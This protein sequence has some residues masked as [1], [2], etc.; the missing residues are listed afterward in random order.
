M[1][2]SNA[3][4]LWFLGESQLRAYYGTPEGLFVA[5][6][7][8]RSGSF[9]EGARVLGASV[10]G[11]LD[12]PVWVAPKEDVIFYSSPGPGVPFDLKRPLRKLWMIRY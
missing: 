3:W 9:S 8:D 1:A 10:T 7:R 11:A 5:V 4:P 12:G 6:R 2:F